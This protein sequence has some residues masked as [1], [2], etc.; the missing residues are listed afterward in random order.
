MWGAITAYMV[1]KPMAEKLDDHSKI[2]MAAN[3]ITLEGALH[4]KKGTNPRIVSDILSNRLAPKARAE[5]ADSN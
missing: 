3:M 2:M 4:L 5:L 1:A